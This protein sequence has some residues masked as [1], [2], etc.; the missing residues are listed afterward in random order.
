[1][2]ETNEIRIENLRICIHLYSDRKAVGARAFVDTYIIR[3]L[4]N[5]VL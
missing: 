4:D 5:N 1:M 3:N 2:R